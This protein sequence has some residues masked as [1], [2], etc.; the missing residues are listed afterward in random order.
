MFSF[1]PLAQAPHTLSLKTSSSSY[2]S[3]DFSLRHPRH[4]RARHT[5]HILPFVD[6]V[7]SSPSELDASRQRYYEALAEA[8]AAEAEY[9]QAQARAR[10][11]EARIERQRALQAAARQRAYEEEVARQAR[12]REIEE[13]Y[14]MVK[15]LKEERERKE[16]IELLK[17]RM[18][19]MPQTEVDASRL[20]PLG[21]QPQTP[22]RREEQE[23][24]RAFF[25]YFYGAT[26]VCKVRL[27]SYTVLM[28]L[29]NVS[30]DKQPAPTQTECVSIPPTTLPLSSA[31]PASASD[32]PLKS[33]SAVPN[34]SPQPDEDAYAKFI[35][36]L[37]GVPLDHAKK[38]SPVKSTTP[39]AHATV[40]VPA[41]TPTETKP[42]TTP[43]IRE[44]KSAEVAAFK[45]FAEMFGLGPALAASNQT[46]KKTASPSTPVRLSYPEVFRSLF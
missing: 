32:A 8:R 43:K 29:S 24:L 18:F 44:D 14:K 21:Q 23:A 2:P 33:R 12:V 45:I 1:V 7:S 31:P 22:D 9:L 3:E 20:A 19:G 27:L 17:R 35:S 46:E 42:P 41:P 13:I 6:D 37:F 10:A 26:P 15:S 28:L 40:P 34:S 11:E 30:M 39:T 36:H 5:Q 16:K 4:T 38:S 25:D